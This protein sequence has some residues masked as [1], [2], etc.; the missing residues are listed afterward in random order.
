MS[1]MKKGSRGWINIVVLL[2]SASAVRGQQQQLDIPPLGT[3]PYGSYSVEK[4]ETIDVTSGNVMINIPLTSMAP[5]AAGFSIPIGLNY[6]SSIYT[7]QATADPNDPSGPFQPVNSQFV[8]TASTAGW[9]YSY[10]YVFTTDY[11]GPVAPYPCSPPLGTQT[12]LRYRLITPD[13][14]SHTLY[15]SGQNDNQTY[16]A[17]YGLNWNYTACSPGFPSGTMNFYTA[18]GSYIRMVWQATG[19]GTPSGGPLGGVWTA[20]FPDGSKVRGTGPGDASDLWDRNTN[21][22]TIIPT[23]DSNGNTTTVLQDD[24]GRT[25]TILQQPGLQ[26]DTITQLGYNN[27]QLQWTINWNSFVLDRNHTYPCNNG[28]YNFN[29]PVTFSSTVVSSIILPDNLQYSFQY[30]AGDSPMQWGQLS[31][32]TLPSG[33]TVQYSYATALAAPLP[34]GVAPLVLPVASKTVTSADEDDS[35]CSTTCPVRT[36][37]STYSFSYTQSAFTNPDGGTTTNTFCDSSG[38]TV[39]NS[40]G[41]YQNRPTP[42]SG[43]V[44]Q[45]VQP[46][47]DTINRLWAADVPAANAPAGANL[48]LPANPYVWQEVTSFAGGATFSA[49]QY[50]YDRNGNQTQIKEDDCITTTCTISATAGLQGGTLLRTTANT[51]A[52][53]TGTAAGAAPAPASCNSSPNIAGCAS[54]STNTDSS[55]YWNTTLSPFLLNLVSQSAV[56]GS[57]PGSTTK[58]TYDN[59]GPLSAGN[60]TQLSQLDSTTNMY[61]N[62]N[63]T[64][65]SNGNLLTTKNPRGF[66][67]QFTYGSACWS[68]PAMSNLYPTQIVQAYG[69]SDARTFTFTWDCYAGVKRTDYD[70]DHP[71]T[72]TFGYDQFGRNSSVQEGSTRITTN[73]YTDAA[74]TIQVLRDRLNFNE[75][76]G[77]LTQ[78]T[79]FDQLGRVRLTQDP[80]GNFAQH[81]YLTPFNT[82][83]SYELVSNPYVAQTG[84]NPPAPNSDATVGWTVTTRDNVGRVTRVEHFSGASVPAPWGSNSVSTGAV[85]TTYNANCSTTTDEAGVSRTNCT[86]GLGRLTSVAE[87]GTG[88][89]TT[90]GYDALDNL[91]SVTQG[92]TTRSFGYSSLKRLTSATNPESG[93]VT[94]VYD[95]N[96]SLTSRTDARNITTTF[97]TYNG[98]DQVTGKSYSDGTP[99]VSYSYNKSWLTQVSSSVFAYN[100]TS[101]DE[102]GRITG[103]NQTTGAPSYAFTQHYYP[104]MGVKDITYPGSSRT[105]TTAY[106]TGGRPVTVSGQIGA[107][108]ATNYVTATNYAAQGEISSLALGNSLTETR[109]YN[110]RLQPTQVQVGT[111]FTIVNRYDPSAGSDLNCSGT[112]VTVSGNNG[113]V[114]AQTVNALLRNYSY[115]GVNRICRAAQGSTWTQGYSADTRGNLAFTTWTGQLPNEPADV[116]TSTGVYTASNRVSGWAYDAS[117]NVTGIP[118]AGGTTVRATCAS[119]VMPGVAMMRAACYDAENRMTSE[120][121]ANGTTATYAYDGDGRRVSKALNGMTTTFVYDPEGQLAQDYGGPTIPTSETGTRYLTTD[122]L[123]STRL[124]TKADGT[125]AVTYDYLPFGMEFAQSADT[126]RIRFTGKERDAETG[127]DYFGARYFS[128]AQGRFTSPDPL[129]SSGRPWDPQSWNRYAH[130]L[131]NPL[132]YSDPTGLYEWD[133]TTLGGGCTDKDLKGGKCD[134]FTK[135]QGQDIVNERKDIRAEL[136]RLDSSK[137]PSLRAV[138]AAIGGEGKDNGVTISMKELHEGVSAQVAFN[139]PLKIDENGN[140][141]LNLSVRPGA[142]GNLLF[143]DLA[144][145]GSHIWDAQAVARG[146]RPFLRSIETELSGYLSSIAAAQALHL[147]NIGPSGGTPFWDSSWSRVDQQTRP[148]PEIVKFLYSSPIYKD[149]LFNVKFAK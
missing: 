100:Y 76:S 63:N 134:G 22:I 33:A 92:S 17:Y 15:V 140:P 121:D 27:Q 145:E 81:R 35:S 103:A 94:Y 115:D 2:A 85:T 46:N 124:L 110:A 78:N 10:R 41:S 73:V 91:T 108:P 99:S 128:G 31:Q 101:F 3:V 59:G 149:E 125:V 43:V 119:N 126:N 112:S 21:H 45:V 105:L 80:A 88:A 93:S 40:C 54:L 122:Q 96:G 89:T 86:D 23:T 130:G 26:K 57:G 19:T 139:V 84:T 77:Q 29:C 87:N 9:R 90:Y 107:N 118:A 11:L 71:L 147:S 111:L 114:L 129:L 136:K 127:L 97:S 5:G 67:T 39:Q 20:Y 12:W 37:T 117:G 72:R 146:N 137:D 48:H 16:P 38:Q 106:D 83:L 143:I 44:Y 116:I 56:S 14:S 58:F 138:A 132:R 49:K 55:G 64:Y 123:G 50:Q 144:H 109:K 53:P 30:N 75:T 42:F 135:A 113:N 13:G 1:L 25:V 131:N 69:T 51:Y 47:G 61:L 36:E 4:L 102:L 62:T 70:Q 95:A 24:L 65:D 104:F 52:N 34:N 6:N 148:G 98:L 32:M 66:T 79:W 141:V 68:G 82:G 60:L 7:W 28:L 133:S 142:S 120:T 18:D 74:R 8:D